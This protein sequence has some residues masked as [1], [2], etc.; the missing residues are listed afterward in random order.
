MSYVGWEQIGRQDFHISKETLSLFY[1]VLTLKIQGWVR[2]MQ[3]GEKGFQI[4]QKLFHS[5]ILQTFCTQALFA[6]KI[7]GWVRD[8]RE[9]GFPNLSKLSHNSS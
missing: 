2:T 7:Q 9:A 4:S 6:L 8:R 5:P 1:F 3:Q